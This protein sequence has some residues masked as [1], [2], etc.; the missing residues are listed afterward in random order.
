MRLGPAEA[1]SRRLDVRLALAI[2]PLPPR[3]LGR[4]E[5]GVGWKQLGQPWQIEMRPRLALRA[6]PR[7]TL[8]RC[9][10]GTVTV[11]RGVAR[12]LRARGVGRELNVSRTRGVRNEA[13]PRWDTGEGRR[14]RKG[15][16]RARPLCRAVACG[17]VQFAMRCQ[18]LIG[19]RAIGYRAAIP[20][21]IRTEA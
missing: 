3:G 1:R 12:G 6:K 15:L 9:R 20:G 4:F 18:C 16:G 21:A 13:V 11:S 10:R 14:G 17:W 2:V 5:A 8:S 19:A 7:Q